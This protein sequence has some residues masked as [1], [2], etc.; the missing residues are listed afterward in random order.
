MTKLQSKATQAI[1]AK[2]TKVKLTLK[3]AKIM[4][5]RNRSKLEDSKVPSNIRTTDKSQVTDK[6]AEILIN[7][8][9]LKL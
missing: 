6:G 2:Q 3:E 1:W 7:R 9:R 8:K 4:I 5:N